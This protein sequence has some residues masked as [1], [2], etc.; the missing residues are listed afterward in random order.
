MMI[1]TFEAAGERY[2]VDVALVEEVVPRVALRRLPSA[3]S[4]VAGLLNYRG[5]VVPVVDLG[6]LVDSLP[7]EHRLSTRVVVFRGDSEGRLLGLAAERVSELTGVSSVELTNLVAP[8]QRVGYLGPVARIDGTLVQM[9]EP[10]RLLA[11][12][13]APLWDSAWLE[14]VSAPPTARE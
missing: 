6:R 3:S 5:K 1:L 8:L 9:I 10:D 14:P 11:E 2:G 13:A 4:A 12:V 7:C